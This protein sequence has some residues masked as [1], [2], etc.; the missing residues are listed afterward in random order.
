MWIIHHSLS[1]SRR[2][3]VLWFDPAKDVAEVIPP[4]LGRNVSEKGHAY[5][6]QVRRGIL[7]PSSYQIYDH[8]RAHTNSF[9]EPG[10]AYRSCAG[11]PGHT[12]LEPEA[13]SEGLRNG[14]LFTVRACSP[15]SSI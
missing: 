1:M 12:H 9:S 4:Y 13:E 3:D 2:I 14:E 11:S 7:R 8:S 15:Q 10:L 5:S 6:N